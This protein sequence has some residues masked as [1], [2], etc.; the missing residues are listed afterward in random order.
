MVLE[1]D[2]AAA[3]NRRV[4]A[5]KKKNS[6]HHTK[7]KSDK[8][9]RKK[10][11]KKKRKK[12]KDK[13]KKEKPIRLPLSCEEFLGGYKTIFVPDD[14]YMEQS[15]SKIDL[16]Y[17]LATYHSL[18]NPKFTTT[19][20][21]FQEVRTDIYVLLSDLLINGVVAGT[22]GTDSKDGYRS[23][24]K[25]IKYN[26]GIDEETGKIHLNNKIFSSTSVVLADGAIHVFSPQ[27]QSNFFTAL[28]VPTV[29]MIPRKALY[30]MHFSN[31]VKEITFRSL[32]YLIDGTTSNQ[33]I[34]LE[35]AQR[36][37]I[38]DDD[39]APFS[40][41]SFSSKQGL[42]YQ[43]A[44]GAIDIDSHIKDNNSVYRLLD[45]KLCSKKK[46]GGCFKLK[47]SASLEGQE[48]KRTINDEVNI[49]S[50]AEQIGNGTFAYITDKDVDTPS[51]F[52]HSLG[53]LI[54]NGAIP[55]HL[56]HIEIDK[57]SCLSTLGYLNEY[58]LFSL[59]DNSKGYSVF[60]PCGTSSINTKNIRKDLTYYPSNKSKGAWKNLGLILNYL[61]GNPALF[62]EI[63]KGM[64][65]E[66]TIYSNFGLSDDEKEIYS[67]NMNGD[68]VKV[69]SF[70]L[71]SHS[72][73]IIG[74]NETQLSMSLNSDILF[75]QGA[76]HII[77][78]ILLPEGFGIPFAD[79][80]KTTSDP[81]YPKH[82]FVDLLGAHP[83]LKK[84]LGLVEDKGTFHHEFSLLVPSYESM[85]DFNITDAF[86]KLLDF[87][88]FHLIP[89]SQLGTLLDCVTRKEHPRNATGSKQDFI[90]KTNL[91]NTELTCIS[92]PNTDKVFLKLRPRP[93]PNKAE[94]DMKSYNKDHEVRLISHGCTSLHY[95]H[96]STNN[97]S[98]IFLLEKPLNL[99]WLDDSK[100]D[101][102]L[103]VHL[104]FVSVGVG[105]ILGLAIF[106]GIMIGAIFCLGNT[107]KRYDSP[108]KDSDSL[109]PRSE[110]SFMRVLTD[111]DNTYY[112]RGYETDIDILRTESDLLLPIYGKKKKKI[113]RRDYGTNATTG[114]TKNAVTSNGATAPRT[115]K[116]NVAK[117]FSRDRNIPGVSQF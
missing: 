13:K 46:I 84:A 57:K 18:Y 39:V 10:K 114:N 76:I 56:D 77:D 5:N 58:N 115:I 42:L 96:N 80:L 85:A 1:D 73:N 68:L 94:L 117:T 16:R 90:V 79:L 108:M 109:F 81:N 61:E 106:G 20:E 88:E 36:D 82:S 44:D 28:K 78:Q 34:F 4:N 112:D 21:A 59:P 113:K 66:S 92:D 75:S 63:L 70:K 7:G 22:N 89:N 38:A 23:I 40:T 101:N 17:Y 27:K 49:I 98:C 99:K 87:L 9:K 64:F 43:F 25:H 15:L 33:T 72:D 71:D 8:K 67:D 105:I 45:S 62:K 3:Y 104:G 37:D 83:K 102:F 30:A 52:K 32:E 103:H 111:D 100:E 48:V 51:N 31:L 41:S 26:V 95:S 47:V 110:S 29:E 14:D 55:R 86:P 116:T 35:S 24:S 69:E 50:S 97:V 65:I 11:P 91:T 12:G 6:R 2:D 107:K 19:E 93:H 60:L 74:L 54:S 53:E